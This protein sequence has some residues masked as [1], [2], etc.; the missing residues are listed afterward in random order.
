MTTD[1]K[2]AA[3]E[4]RTLLQGQNYGKRLGELP[5]S[6]LQEIGELITV[7]VDGVL[8][9]VQ[10]PVKPSFDDALKSF[11]E[12]VNAMVR[13]HHQREGYTLPPPTIAIDP[14]G[15]KYTRIVE[16]DAGGP[17]SVWCFVEKATG[18]ILKAEGWKRPAKHARGNIYDANPLAGVD[19]HGPLYLR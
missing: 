16:C 14:R 7:L 15:K 4:L 6:S 11:V 18:N 12:K 13:E 10:E 2:T 1:T 8:G 3:T 5:E 17:R 9:P 19:V